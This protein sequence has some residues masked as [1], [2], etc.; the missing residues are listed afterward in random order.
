MATILVYKYFSKKDTDVSPTESAEGQPEAQ[1]SGDSSRSDSRRWMLR[2]SIALFI[3][4]FFE[5]LDYTVV[6]TAQTHIA[7]A[8]DQLSLQSWIGTA[9]LLTSTVFL[10]LF[11]SIVEIWGRHTTLHLSLLIF[12]IGSAISTGSNN[13]IT[14]LVGRG[15]AGVGAA[16]LQS[17][18]KILMS[19][20]SSLDANNLQR[21]L[22]FL[23]FAVGYCVG[24]FIGG[25]L[26]N[27]SYRW[28]FAINLPACVVGMAIAFIVL[29]NRTKGP[30]GRR[31]LP[32]PADETFIQKLLQVDWIGAILF[33][34]GGILVIL[35]LN[36]GTIYGWSSAR[37]VVC[38]VV[39]GLLYVAFVFFE[40]FLE[41]HVALAFSSQTP[42][43]LPDPMLPLEVF[44]SLD[45]CLIEASVFVSGMVMMVIFYSISTFMTIVAGV[46][47]SKAGAQL[48]FFAP[49]MGAGSITQILWIKR[50]RQPKVPI[51]LGGAIIAVALGLLSMA[52][53][54]SN[55]SMIDGFMVLTG[56]GVGLSAGSL[57]V[58]ARFTLPD[59]KVAVVS[60]LS[61]FFRA[62]GGTIGLA[63]CG[64]VLNAKVKSYLGD[65]IASGTISGTYA[66]QLA[67]P[68]TS[69]TSLQSIDGL[70][71]ELQLYVREAFRV[72]TRWAFI[73]LVPWA[74]LACIGT[75]F[76]SKI[77]D[78]DR[79]PEAPEVIVVEE[80]QQKESPQKEEI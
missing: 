42:T 20:S 6:A 68:A 57:A 45:I 30:Q 46:S 71:I 7:S 53:E 62:F 16:G 37:V 8:F 9:Y 67:Q 66:G 50:F 69:L 25:V 32:V 39:G 26:L 63:Q 35:A 31:G 34:T 70:P 60:T 48:I 76:L 80:S 72:G 40:W 27:I 24:P 64:A 44:R 1:A 52:L 73:S 36:W 51:V 15:V 11:A 4:V 10:P 3:P 77:R 61:L 43:L 28:I 38:F 29:R 33:L 79:E 59:D 17:V 65:L 12:M 47:A 54:Q 21:S 55:E 23:L 13:M 74:A 5:T 2:L 22:V 18:V 41:R 14:M 75:L 56:V 19:D 58:H 49:G 78:T